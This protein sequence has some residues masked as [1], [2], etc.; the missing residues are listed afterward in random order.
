MMQHE[1]PSIPWKIYNERAIAKILGI[2]ARNLQQLRLEGRGP[3][4]V[5]ITKRRIG[6]TMEAIQAWLAAR[7]KRSTSSQGPAA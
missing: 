2:S 5:Q 1:T 3:D 7:T 6:Y 4:Y